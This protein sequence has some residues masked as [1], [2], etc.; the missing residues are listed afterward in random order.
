MR[1]LIA[2]FVALASSACMTTNVAI[3]QAGSTT[4]TTNPP[5]AHVFINGAEVCA[6]TPCNWME[7]DGL[8]HRYHL[9]V[10]K[11]GYQ[12]IDLYLD[13]ELQLFSSFGSFGGGFGTPVG[14][15]VPRQVSFTLEG[16]PG[17]PPPVVPPVP[18]PPGQPAPPPQPGL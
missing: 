16:A 8:A 11:E 3:T 6:S 15:K 2:A 18:P 9:Q 10:R 17:A 13:K 4:I 14:Y 5:G 7:G 12:E 1:A